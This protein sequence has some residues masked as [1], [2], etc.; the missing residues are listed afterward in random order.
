MPEFQ[1]EKHPQNYLD[2]HPRE[3]LRR[4]N[5]TYVFVHGGCFSGG[6]PDFATRI[7][8]DLSERH[9]ERVIV[10]QHRTDR[11]SH[12]VHDVI[13]LVK[14][15][16]GQTPKD[17]VLCGGSS[18]GYIARAVAQY[19]VFEKMIL[20]CPVANPK[21]RLNYL[22]SCAS[23]AYSIEP[24]PPGHKPSED[25]IRTIRAQEKFVFDMEVDDLVPCDTLIIAGGQDLDVPLHTLSD[26]IAT[27]SVST[28]VVGDGTHD[29]QR[30]IP[31][32]VHAQ[33]DAF[34]SLND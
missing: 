19:M 5:R 10:P 9:G 6:T 1:N 2:F 24:S 33:I 29:L 23:F 18:G 3:S 7:A 30:Y 12:A 21:A 14:H 27:P 13:A 4:G 28:F 8:Q 11:L 26:I 31:S 17:L 20:F 34:L 22:L 16:F 25:A 15:L 32:N